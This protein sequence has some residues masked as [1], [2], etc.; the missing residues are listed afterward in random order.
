MS[1]IAPVERA[2]LFALD[3]VHLSPL[4]ANPLLHIH[5]PLCSDEFS[6][7]VAMHEL[8][9]GL[10]FLLLS[11]ASHTPSLL[12]LLHPSTE[13]TK[14]PVPSLSGFLFDVHAVQVTVVSVFEHVVHPY[15]PPFVASLQGAHIFLLSVV[16]VGK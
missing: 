15:T 8:P 3:D 7:Q 2:L 6:G 11:H 9:P 14:H 12:Q 16:V 5:V 13:H 4:G 1:A 10:T